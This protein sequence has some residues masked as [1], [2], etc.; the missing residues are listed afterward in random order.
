MALDSLQSELVECGG[1]NVA[2]NIKEAAP[3]REHQDAPEIFQ[4]K[5]ICPKD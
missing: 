4:A 5:G 3:N 1:D 2:H